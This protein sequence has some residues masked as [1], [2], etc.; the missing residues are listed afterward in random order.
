MS[1]RDTGGYFLFGLVAWAFLSILDGV[2]NG[3][4]LDKAAK[5][6]FL[7]EYRDASHALENH[8]RQFYS[9]GILITDKE[10]LHVEEYLEFW[11][12]GLG[13]RCDVTLRTDSDRHKK[14]RQVVFS[15]CPD[16]VYSLERTS[17][18]QSWQ[19]RAVGDGGD[20]SNRDQASIKYQLFHYGRRFA[21]ACSG[22]EAPLR[23][24]VEDKN[25][26]VVG[27]AQAPDG[28]VRIE[29]DYRPLG[30][31]SP[32]FMNTESVSRISGWVLLNPDAFWCIRE[33]SVA[34]QYKTGLYV[35]SQAVE[36]SKDSEG[37]PVPKVV[38]LA[39]KYEDHPEIRY[40]LHLADVVRA[41]MPESIFRLGQFGLGNLETARAPGVSLV[42]YFFFGASFLSLALGV[43][44]K[45]LGI[46][47]G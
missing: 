39:L 18:D 12:N 35:R 31:K 37:F 29:F 17:Q 3:Q 6:R 14:G 32:F 13:A 24:L 9:S 28:E 2:T 23:S 11:I 26:A 7:G 15:W 41:R 34:T 40:S 46:G 27:A 21:F 43:G 38:R 5:D 19:V 20:S 25:F 4:V 36:Y 16:L 45:H 42:S 47:R 44:I 22:I 10:D 33:G 8:Y 1:L 30:G